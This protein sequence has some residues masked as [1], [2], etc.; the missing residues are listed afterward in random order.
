MPIYLCFKL[1]SS[2][3]SQIRRKNQNSELGQ[4][5]GLVETTS[6]TTGEEERAIQSEMGNQE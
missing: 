2:Q 4:V 3:P 5:K 6:E 1:K